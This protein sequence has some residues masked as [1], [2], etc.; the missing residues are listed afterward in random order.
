MA[1]LFP[2]KYVK[3]VLIID[4]DADDSILLEEAIVETDPRIKCKSLLNG[5]EAIQYLKLNL[6]ALPDLIFLDLNMPKLDGKQFLKEVLHYPEL[7]NIF[8]VVY[9]TS[10]RPQDAVETKILGA[11]QYLMKPSSF[12]KLKE[13]VKKVLDLLNTQSQKAH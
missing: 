1:P 11:F 7:K 12:Y 6:H 9:S 5:L 13:E 10:K 3:N 4:D 8:I 2:D